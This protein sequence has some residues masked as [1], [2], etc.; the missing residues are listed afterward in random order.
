MRLVPLALALLSVSG[1]AIAADDAGFVPRESFAPFVMPDPAT[2]YRSAS[3]LPGPA[4]WQNRADY[5]IKAKLDPTSDTLTGD[6][7]I[8]Y[9]NHSPDA[10][11]VDR[12]AHV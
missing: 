5:S 11:A 8:T 3:G 4:Y 2:A 6:E 9:T 1:A 10:L 12:R 7:T